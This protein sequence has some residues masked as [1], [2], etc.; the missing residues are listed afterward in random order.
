MTYLSKNRTGAFDIRCTITHGLDISILLE[1]LYCA[2]VKT[3]TSPYFIVMRLIYWVLY[4]LLFP[5]AVEEAIWSFMLSL[6][7][8]AIFMVIVS[9]FQSIESSRYGGPNVVDELVPDALALPGPEFL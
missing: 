5:V 1:R 7:M 6:D 2:G 3:G 8:G 4:T 9:S